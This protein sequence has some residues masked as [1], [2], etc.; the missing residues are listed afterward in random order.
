MVLIAV[1]I[2]CFFFYLGNKYPEKAGWGIIIIYPLLYA[3][4]FTIVYNSFYPFNVHHAV[5]FIF[6]G[7]TVRGYSY[8]LPLKYMFKSKFVKAS[9]GFVFFIF[10]VSTQESNR[11]LPS[12][13]FSLKLLLPMMVC[14]MLIKTENDLFRMGKILVWQSTFISIFIVLEYLE[15]VN[16]PYIISLIDQNYSAEVTSEWLRDTMYRGGNLRAKGLYGN[17]VDTGFALAFYLPLSIW[18]YMFTGKNINA[19]PFLTIIISLIII[20]T[21]ASILASIIAFIIILPLAFFTKKIKTTRFFTLIFIF[22]T[23]FLIML[24]IIPSLLISI[25]FL[26]SFLMDSLTGNESTSRVKFMRV[27]D[28][29]DIMNNKLFFGYFVSPRYAYESINYTDDLPSIFI[30]FISGG[31]ALVTVFILKIYY[32]LNDIFKIIKMDYLFNPKLKLFFVF[33]LGSILAGIICVFSADRQ[34]H[35]LMMNMLYIGIFS[36]YQNKRIL[37]LKSLN[38]KPKKL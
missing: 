4:N 38:N 25:D 1:F 12:L 2:A 9:I 20:L 6:L 34:A 27:E 21:R 33:S 30:Y 24:I 18:F 26:Y 36:V 11:I 31:L 17:G 5:L 10:I 3:V 37:Y 29:F 32:W 22:A 15:I 35:F 7:M 8:N 28:V 23:A 16:L 14:Y 13:F 19:L